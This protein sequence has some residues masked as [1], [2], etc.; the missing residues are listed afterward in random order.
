[1]KTRTGSFSLA[2]I[3][4]PCLLWAQSPSP[5][6]PPPPEASQFDYLLGDWTYTGV[7]RTPNGER[8]GVGTWTARKAFDGF[9]V[10]DEWRIL[11]A[12]GGNTVYLGTTSRVYSAAKGHW[13]MRFISVPGMT[14]H[15]QY[16]EW[17]DGEMHLWWTGEDQQGR[18]YQMRV[19]YYDISEDSFRW[20]GDRS[21][22]GGRTWVEN[23]LTMEVTRVAGSQ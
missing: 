20:R 19:R 21:Y 3:L 11:D 5:L 8:H 18:Q 7:W 6:P 1:M 16:A 10:V 13:D 14:W 22:D 12:P 23:W 2:L 17:R 9:G 15:E 4:M